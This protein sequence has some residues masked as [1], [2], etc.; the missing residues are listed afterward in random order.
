M[1][2]SFLT[3]WKSLWLCGG[4]I[5]G[6]ARTIICRCASVANFNFPL[7]HIQFC[8]HSQPKRLPFW[9]LLGIIWEIVSKREDGK[10][11]RQT[12]T[13]GVIVQRAA[14]GIGWPYL[15]AQ[16]RV[17]GVA[18]SVSVI[19]TQV[20]FPSGVFILRVSAGALTAQTWLACVL[21]IFLNELGK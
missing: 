12:V 21:L 19:T 6:T 13:Q 8:F 1:N 17:E 15:A 4:L 7:E 20:C 14:K 3:V 11:C 10:Q 9:A 2:Q 5:Y 18:H 16:N